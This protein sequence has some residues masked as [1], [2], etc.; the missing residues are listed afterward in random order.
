V[1][2]DSN[3][4]DPRYWNLAGRVQIRHTDIGRIKVNVL[5]AQMPDNADAVR[6]KINSIF[7]AALHKADSL[8]GIDVTVINGTTEKDPAGRVIQTF[9]LR[10]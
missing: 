10:S 7:S 4:L 5:L 3:Q 1:L 6:L 9:A 8:N 2:P